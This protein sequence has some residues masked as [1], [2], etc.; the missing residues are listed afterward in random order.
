[1]GPNWTGPVL[2][3]T[4]FVS[5]LFCCNPSLGSPPI[6]FMIHTSEQKQPI[7]LD[8]IYGL[9]ESSERS[10]EAKKL[11]ARVLSII[12]NS[13]HSH[14]NGR[15]D[16]E[17]TRLAWHLMEA[18]ALT[19]MRHRVQHI[20]PAIDKLLAE[21]DVSSD[22][23]LSLNIWLANLM[24][25]EHWATRMW[26]SWGDLLPAGHFE[27]SYT[28]LGSYQACLR[29]EANDES[30]GEP[31]YCMVD[32]QPLI[33]G[34]PRFHS[35][36]SKAI[37]VDAS[38]QLQY[39]TTAATGGGKANETRPRQTNYNIQTET[40]AKL[41]EQAQYF[42]YIN[43]RFGSC[44]P[45][46]CN[47]TEVTTIVQQA[48]SRVGLQTTQ[49][50]CR[51]RSEQVSWKL[52]KH[53]WVAVVLLGSTGAFVVILSIFDLLVEFGDFLGLEQA[54]L[55]RL[56]GSLGDLMD[57][58]SI[59]RNLARLF[60]VDTPG[61]ALLTIKSHDDHVAN[62]YHHVR[63]DCQLSFL[64]G[65]R[66]ITMIW[67]I[68]GHTLLNLNYSTLTHMYRTLEGQLTSLIILPS[69]NTNFSVDTFFVISGLLNSYI[70]FSLKD[71][72]KLHFNGMLFTA[73]RYLRL[74]PQL[75]V[76]ILLFFLIPL[77]GNGPLYSSYIEP[78]AEKCYKN[79]WLNLLYMQTYFNRNEMCII[80]SWW[81][82]MEMSFYVMSLGVIYALIW[83]GPKWGL[84]LN[85]S[86][87][88]TLTLAGTYIHYTNSFAI[89]YLP[90][91]PQRYEV[92]LEQTRWFFHRP[93]PHA[94]S[95]F[96]GL[97]LG[98]LYAVGKLKPLSLFKQLLCWLVV[99]SSLFT[100]LL[101]P[102]N[103]NKGNPYTRLEAT[104]YYM[105]CQLL[106][107]LGVG[108][109]IVL[110]LLGHATWLNKLLSARIFVP[111]SRITY[112]TY[113]THI[114]VVYYLAASLQRT[115]EPTTIN[116]TYICLANLI[117]SLC[118]AVVLSLIYEAP[119][120]RLLKRFEVRKFNLAE[121][122]TANG[123]PLDQQATINNRRR[124]TTSRLT[125]RKTLLG[126]NNG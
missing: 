56:D 45:S 12:Q 21:S 35:I 79:Y 62:L 116:L 70:V 75:V 44:W 59:R 93:Y 50:H 47:R 24:R 72:L 90:S 112:M 108:C 34:R 110:C 57:L 49:T 63:L 19:Y 54:S 10:P 39:G 32:L 53:Q 7:S 60:H 117:V 83:Y 38:G 31:R 80:P 18:Q 16:L 36:F 27:G 109:L 87:A 55:S 103:W 33:P 120:T 119:I 94:A 107:P 81:L 40:F 66:V 114:L 3:L 67:I 124:A 22:C 52:N 88:T 86:I 14:D 15:V 106:W 77:A 91:I 99:I 102:Y 76:T 5:F 17:V 68:Y 41:A 23:K 51:T 26:N 73:A 6:D 25:L 113:L 121:A 105:S 64:N 82:S 115:Y 11:A 126:S 42:Y 69:L 37:K 61:L 122:A 78:E 29:T 95:Y 58:C 71:R 2:A 92:E 96:I 97:A 30:V 118:L 8:S 28:D 101:G 100:T 98:Y 125:Y 74:T 48:A 89:A 9:D 84:A 4:L 85:A 46:N 1:M 111:L 20:K 43:F 65:L 13:S 104:I 123:L